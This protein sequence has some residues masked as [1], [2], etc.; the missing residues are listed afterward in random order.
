M[1]SSAAVSGAPEGS[2]T[3]KE[4]QNVNWPLRTVCNNKSCNA[5]G[6]WKCPSCGNKNFQGR[7]VCNK[8]S[9][10]IP[11]P[12]NVEPIGKGGA[13]KGSPPVQVIVLPQAIPQMR[14]GKGGAG[15][16]AGGA[17]PGSWSCPSCGNLNWPLRTTCNNKSCG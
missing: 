15:G 8:K 12:D 9:C 3:C 4:C 11:R 17:P 2:W 7:D 14:A 13:G 10:G 6:P 1:M 5:L 16:G